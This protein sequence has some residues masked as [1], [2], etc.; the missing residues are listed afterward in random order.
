MDT[1]EYIQKLVETRRWLIATNPERP[2]PSWVNISTITM[3][4]KF[5]TPIDI[6]D[7]ESKFQEV[8]VRPAGSSGEGFTWR[9]NKDCNFYNQVTIN[10]TDDYSKKSVK[11]FP[12]GSVHVCGCSNPIDCQRVLNQIKFLVKFFVN[13]EVE[14]APPTICMINTNFS[15]NVKVNLKKVIDAF[16]SQKSQFLVSFDPA[17]YSA[18][19]VKFI[20]GEGMK[21][22]TA[23][24]F[25]TGRI[26]VTGAKQLDEIAAAYRIL[27]STM[28][29]DIFV[30]KTVTE[31]K[32]ET[33]MGATY[34][35]WYRVLQ[36]KNIQQ[37]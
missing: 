25:K 15:L 8:A 6:S 34:D 27:N 14:L 26:L 21:K 18:V 37:S 17:R 36:N 12:N 4:S 32:F 23:S 22:V 3:V 5:S 33:I 7:F 35:E 1:H 16:S 30:S 29:D 28:T 2:P 31:E 19:K 11:L 9:I 10:Y 20:P 13:K 24:I